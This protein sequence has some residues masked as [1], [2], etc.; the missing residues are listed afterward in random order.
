VLFIFSIYLK[1]R[2]IEMIRI[3][4]SADWHINLHK[5]KVP[6]NWQTSRFQMMFDRLHDLEKRCDV[7]V[8]AGDL[9]D[10]KPEPMKCVCYFL[11]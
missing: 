3:L 7:H 8:I 1:E 6:Y 2:Q 11:I 9:F 10:K 5:K 4:S